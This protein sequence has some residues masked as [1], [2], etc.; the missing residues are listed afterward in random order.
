MREKKIKEKRALF[1][2]RLGNG[3]QLVLVGALTGA[4]VGVIVTCYTLLAAMSEEFSRGY[5][6]FFR[7]N[8]AFIPLLFLA[9]ALGS[10]VVGGIVRF[11]PYIRGSGI[12][13]RRAP[14]AGSC[15]FRGTV[16]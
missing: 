2:R 14:C 7:D 3:L 11:L 6:G 8:P 1:G 10:V 9:L 16:R 13:R 12:R 4:F 5:Y 15:A